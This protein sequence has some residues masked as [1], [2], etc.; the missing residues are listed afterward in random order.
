[1]TRGTPFTKGHEKVGGRKR[2]VPNTV[3]GEV[4]AIGRL[5]LSD[6]VYLKNL[7]QRLRDGKAG[8]VEPLLWQYAYGKPNH[9]TG[10]AEESSPHPWDLSTLSDKELD[11]LEGLAVK[12]STNGSG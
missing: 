1:M 7:T 11:S 2:G 4:R 9:N 10:E 5:L 3:Q 6:E 12:A 8:P